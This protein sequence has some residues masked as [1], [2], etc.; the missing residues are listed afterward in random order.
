MRDRNVESSHMIKY[1]NLFAAIGWVLAFQAIMC[2]TGCG[3]FDRSKIKMPEFDFVTTENLHSIAYVD[4]EHIWVCGNYGTILFSADR[5]K[6]WQPQ[7]SGISDFLLCTITFVDRQRGWAGGVGGRVVHTVDGGTTWQEQNTGTDSNILDLFF[8]DA[9]KGW[10]VGEFGTVI[11]TAD[12]GSTWSEQREPQDTLYNDVFFVD[13]SFGWI[14]G[15]FGTILHTTDDGATW[16]PQECRDIV[17][18]AGAFEWERPLP[19]LYGLYFLDR[20]RG[21]IVGM[22]GVILKTV[23]GGVNWEKI[24]SGTDKPL[25]SLA[26]QGNRG[27]IVGNKGVYLQSDNGGETWSVRDGLIKTKF[28]LREVAFNNEQHGL[29]V[30]AQGAIARTESG[31]RAWDLLSGFRYDMEEFGLAD[32]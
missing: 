7:K 30:G 5:G 11:H 17:P 15:E 31:G 27:W 4:A 12:G 2:M 29:I 13:E 21:W 26:V 32:F 6:N 19:A 25:Y 10:A 22:D 23:D 18:Q 24:E 14:V 16:T 20:R 28:W 1:N 8:L 3:K 9:K